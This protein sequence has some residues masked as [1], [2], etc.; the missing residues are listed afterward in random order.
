VTAATMLTVLGYGQGAICAMALCFLLVRRMWRNY[1][2]LGSFLAV[3]LVTNL[4]LG[5]LIHFAGLLGMHSAY[6]AYFW[7]YWCSFVVLA[8]LTFF[9][10]YGIFRQTVGPLKG[11]QRLGSLTFP[12]AAVVLVVLAPGSAL[13]PHQ[14]GMMFVVGAISQLLRAQSVL[15]L[16]LLLLVCLA[17]RSLGV[18]LRSKVFGVSMG[19]GLLAVNELA[20]SWWLSFHPGISVYSLIQN[21][22]ACAALAIWAIYLAMQEPARQEIDMYGNSALLRWNRICLTWY[23]RKRG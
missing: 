7:V 13:A 14:T 9:I 23:P 2:A 16:C 6:H 22:A 1:W 12:V 20:G 15:T 10:L 19:L 11:L 3:R 17:V 21:V 8:V 18:S 4:T 5:L